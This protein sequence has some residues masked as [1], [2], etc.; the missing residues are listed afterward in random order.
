V[1]KVVGMFIAEEHISPDDRR[2]I[3][4]AMSLWSTLL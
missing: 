4:S 3:E 1:I 2:I